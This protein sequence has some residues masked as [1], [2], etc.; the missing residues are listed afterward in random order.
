MEKINKKDVK[1]ILLIRNDKIGDFI[2][3]SG[4]I[5]ELKKCLPNVEISVV[6]SPS[7]KSLVEKNKNVSKIF[8]RGYKPKNWRDAFA[9]FR[10]A[11]E[12]RKE[13]FDVG[14]DLRGAIL[15]TFFLLFLGNVRY[16]S[17]FDRNILARPFLD[18]KRKVNKKEHACKDMWDMISEVLEVPRTTPWPD[19]PV[20]EEDEKDV[21]EFIKKHKLTKFICLVPDA[22]VEKIQWNLENWDKIIKFI[23][24]KYPEYKILLPGGNMEK[25]IWIQKRNPETIIPEPE[26]NKNL[27]AVYLLFKKSALVMSQ[28]GGPMI[29]AWASKTNTI[30]IRDVCNPDEHTKPLGKNAINIYND[31]NKITVKE[32]KEAISRSL[33]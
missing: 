11:N 21:E 1:K 27:R 13:K 10:T 14:F 28:E 30:S 4:I 16:R 29:M 33:G 31:I 20:D 9:F 12:I 22:T 19:I 15:N 32:V 17:G 23:R 18:F 7:N 5:K 2:F 3:A 25:L 24:K 26:I 8:V 6:A